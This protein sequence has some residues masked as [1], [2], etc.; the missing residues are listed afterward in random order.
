MKNKR[1]WVY[2]DDF[3]QLSI[4]VIFFCPRSQGLPKK[5]SIPRAKTD[6]QMSGSQKWK[7][8]VVGVHSQVY[9]R[10]GTRNPCS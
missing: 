8:G 4:F 9:N 7:N 2:K 1:L 6:L 5:K 3:F 10:S